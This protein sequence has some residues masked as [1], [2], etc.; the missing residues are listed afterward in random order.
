M[1]ASPPID[2]LDHR[3]LVET[4][5]ELAKV[6]TDVPMGTEVFMEPDDPKLVHYVQRVLRPKLV[7]I[8]AYD[9][10]DV[11][12]NQIVAR[13]GEGRSDRVMLVQVYTPTQHHNLMADPWSGKIARAG[14][15]G[16]DEPCVFGQGVTQNKSHQAIALTILKLL[17]EHCVPL[18]GTLY[19]AINNEGRSSHDCSQAILDA[20]DRKPDFGLLMTATNRRISLGNRG[21]VDVNVT[22]EGK[23]V[24]SSSPDTGLSAIEGAWEVMRRLK[25]MALPGTHPQLGGR[26][27]IPYQV[28]YA[29]L[30]PHT[31]PD[32]ARLRVDRRLLPGDDPSIAT[33]EVRAA[34]ADMSPYRVTVA[35][36]QYMWPALVNPAHPGIVALGAA[37]EMEHG[38]PPATYYGQGTFDAGGPCAAGVPTVMYGVGGGAGVL[39]ED[40]VPLS[41]LAQVARVVTRTILTL[42]Q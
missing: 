17:H 28:S 34:L 42:L 16:Y 4:L 32:T 41:H 10:L 25:A 23:A 36:G 8:G 30:A 38:T 11:E 9:L 20:L 7:A 27:V 5:V 6:P 18:A 2:R 21:R 31:L 40:F 3:F 29:P 13:Y 24:H 1:T 39:D 19:V 15:W 12:R 35:Q 14:A 37:H 26:H 22:V 33:S